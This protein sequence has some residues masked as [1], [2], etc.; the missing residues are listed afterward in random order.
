MRAALKPGVSLIGVSAEMAIAFV[1]INAV[2]DEH[3]IPCVI[4]S[5]TD[6]T[7]GNNSLHYRGRALDIRLPSRYCQDD[8]VDNSVLFDIKQALGP[9]FDCVLET[10]HV[11]VELDP[12]PK[13]IA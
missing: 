10:D 6:G 13:T 8:K 4:T 12:K 5:G 1:I 7:H 9:D 11:H 2:F 3:G